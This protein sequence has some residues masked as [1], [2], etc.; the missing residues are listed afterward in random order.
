L[1]QDELL[2]KTKATAAVAIT[3]SVITI[4][5]GIFMIIVMIVLYFIRNMNFSRVLDTLA[6]ILV[7]ACTIV[8]DYK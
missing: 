8:C 1:I 6:N 3:A 7:R 2:V 5:E 4:T